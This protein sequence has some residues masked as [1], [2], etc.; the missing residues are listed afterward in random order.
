M[1]APIQISVV[2]PTRNRKARLVQAL[3]ALDASTYPVREV[4][5]VD[6]SDV[7]LT[8]AVLPQL[9]HSVLRCIHMEPGVCPQRNAGIR[10]AASPWI[11]LCDDDM[12]VHPEYLRRLAAAL[13]AAPAIGAVSGT[14]MQPDGAGWVPN[15]PLR[16]RKEL[17]LKYVFG[18][19]VWGPLQC[20]SYPWPLS[21]IR[22][23]YAARGNHL[24]A[25]GWPVLTDFGGNHFDTP[26]YTLGAALVRRDWLLDAPFD[27]VLD[28]HGIGEN[29]SVVQRFPS[30]T[31]RIITGA[32]VLHHQEPA[33]R[34]RQSLQY[35]RRTLALDY[36]RRTIPALRH[37]RRHRLLWSLFGNWIIYAVQ[38]NAA[39]RHASWRSFRQL[40]FGPNP[41]AQAA[42]RNER[43]CCPEL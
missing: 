43:L 42:A 9:Q 34:L 10:L 26:L 4:I 7:A 24:S 39:M 20:P 25:A 31:V 41:Y 5:V 38:R 32:H 29:F 40:L 23:R 13:V 35:Y 19:G 33:N 15:F 2:I 36:F 6:S 12:E 3:R 17:L 22:R 1:Q 18:L 11:F 28:P 30:Q 37:V 8:A 21:A 14:V 16:S 27:E